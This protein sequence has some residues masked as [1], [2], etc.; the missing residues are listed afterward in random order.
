MTN[1]FSDPS[2]VANSNYGV[3]DGRRLVHPES[4]EPAS[5]LSEFVHDAVRALVLN[6]H[7]TCV[8]GKSSFRQGAYRFGL[9]DSLASPASAAGLARDLFTFVGELP[10]FGDV[11]STFVASF[12]GPHPA[13][14]QAFE[15]N[16]WK[17]LQMLHDLD[18]N[19]H[20]WDPTVSADPSD[21][22]FSF[23]FA[24]VAFFVIGLH[25]ASTRAARRFAWPTLVFNSHRQFE[26]LKRHG[27]YQRFQAVIRD[28]ERSLQGDVNPML[29]EFGTRSE[30]AQY[31]GRTVDEGWTCPF[32][33][34][35]H[36]G[37]TTD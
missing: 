30:A 10:S 35:A 3:F 27:G 31:S 13:D 15:S 4:G 28:N 22:R 20:A 6:E 37:D 33:V 16:L 14:E 12:T 34:R 2:A 7:F 23:S 36:D 5:A 8:G 29:S 17:T 32:H 24:G 1:P 18:A 21:A 9:Y 26:E 25:A 11:F 19:Y